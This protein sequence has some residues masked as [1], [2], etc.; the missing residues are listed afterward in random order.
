MNMLG[1]GLAETG[2]YEDALSVR[3]A[4]L[5]VERRVGAPEDSILIVQS[6]LANTYQRLG[7]NEEALCMTRDVYLGFLK[8]NGEENEETLT[9]AHN[10]ASSLLDLQRFK[11]TKALLRKTIPVARRVLGKSHDLTL[12][13]KKVYANALYKGAGATLDELRE[14]VTTLEDT[15]RIRRR[16]FG[17]SHPT[18]S[19]VEQTLRNARAALRAREAPSASA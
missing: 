12:V 15:E 19:N 7:R 8:L 14:S 16:V 6:N 1:N 18:T 10:Y 13:M 4:E 2:H 17:D 11:E 3:E 9:T 5:S